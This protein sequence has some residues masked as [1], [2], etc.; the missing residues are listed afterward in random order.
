MGEE[1][2]LTNDQTALDAFEASITEIERL[3]EMTRRFNVFEAMGAARQEIRH[4]NFLA[5]LMDPTGKHGF[6]DAFLLAFLRKAVT[7]TESESLFPELTSL[8]DAEVRREWMNIDV[9]AVSDSNKLVCVVENKIDTGEHDRQLQRYRE[10][11]ES[12]YPDHRKILL[13]LTPEGDMPS[14][15]SYVPVTYSLVKEVVEG[16]EATMRSSLAQ[17]VLDALRQYS[18]VIGRHIVGDS[19]IAERCRQI[20]KDHRRAL[21]LLFEHK[22][23]INQEIAEF[24]MQLRADAAATHGVI[25]GYTSRRRWIAFYNQKLN[26]VTEHCRA[27]GWTHPVEVFCEFANYPNWLGLFVYLSERGEPGLREHV[28]QQ[29]EANSGAFKGMNRKLNKGATHFYSREILRQKD[30]EKHDF[31]K[32]TAKIQECWVRFLDVELP[33]MEKVLASI[34]F[35]DAPGKP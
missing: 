24:L 25:A 34:V 9:L 17:E 1:R 19:D 33:A 32:M 23:G 28:W 18:E 11:V 16:L 12:A 20:Y 22:P 10:V 21:D 29:I 5:S 27:A 26:S 6:G 15:D 31:E 7:G 4:S 30:Y 13:Y 3:D 35:P 2:G 14:D 8:E